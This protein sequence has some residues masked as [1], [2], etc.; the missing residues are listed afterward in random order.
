MFVLEYLAVIL[1]EKILTMW[2]CLNEQISR[3]D[4]G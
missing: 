3:V 2:K 4:Q 1:H